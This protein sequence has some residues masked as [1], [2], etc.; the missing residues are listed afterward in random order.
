MKTGWTKES[1]ISLITLIV[2]I[3]GAVIAGMALNVYI[4]QAEELKKQSKIQIELSLRTAENA[5]Y[6]M[7]AKEEYL[8]AFFADPPDKDFSFAD[9]QK[10]VNLFLE[11]NSFDG[12]NNA[13]E[14]LNRLYDPNDNFHDP[15]KVRL[16]KA[17]DLAE[18][19]LY[20]LQDA[21]SSYQANILCEAQYET[22]IAYVDDMGFNPLFLAALYFGHSS[23]YISKDF[24]IHIKERLLRND[25]NKQSAGIIYKKLLQEDWIDGL[26]KRGYN[27][28]MKI[29]S[30]N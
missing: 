1:C 11:K 21:H 4:N 7:T 9:A 16:R 17:F 13:E 26:G 12:W 19:L 22:W 20:L 18:H 10:Y 28:H 2:Y 23:G 24:A 3:A 29:S 6:E 8:M 30:K 27:D 14:L 5:V 15:N 25:V